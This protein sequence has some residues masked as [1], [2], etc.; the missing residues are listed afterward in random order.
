MAPRMVLMLARNTGATPNPWP[1]EVAEAPFSAASGP[2]AGCAVAVGTWMEASFDI[3]LLRW[4]SWLTAGLLSRTA[5]GAR[6]YGR[7]GAVSIA[8]PRVFRTEARASDDPGARAHR[9]HW[10]AGSRARTAVN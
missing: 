3:R 9:W 7:R 10:L 1:V 2:S 4:I 5:S 8:Q 6:L